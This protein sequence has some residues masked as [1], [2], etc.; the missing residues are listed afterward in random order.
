MPKKK[1]K[2][3]T[4]K[5]ARRALKSAKEQNVFTPDQQMKII[6]WLAEGLTTKEI[7]VKAAMEKPS[8]Y[9][10]A[11]DVYYYRVT[12]Q[13]DVD[14]AKRARESEALSS[15]FAL[16]EN[17]VTALNELAAKIFGELMSDKDSKLWLK[18]VKGIGSGLDYERIDY[19]EFNRAGVE[20]VRGLLDDIALEMKDRVRRTDVTTKDKPITSGSGL[21][22]ALWKNL[23]DDELEILERAAEILERPASSED[24]P[25]QDTNRS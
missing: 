11:Q 18:M 8:F 6:L 7:S 21:D 20:T 1:L 17:R 9:V 13:I 22:P 16:K 24:S 5:G 15:G 2:V 4:P 3:L 12:R 23:S 10:N 19:E 25:A 14:Q